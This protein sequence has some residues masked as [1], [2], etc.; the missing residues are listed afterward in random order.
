MSDQDRP[1]PPDD[2]PLI[3]GTAPPP[4][5]PPPPQEPDENFSGVLPPEPARR[6]VDPWEAQ[7]LRRDAYDLR[8]YSSDGP[9]AGYYGATRRSPARTA[10]IYLFTIMALVIGGVL[11]FLLFRVLNDDPVDPV[12]PT[13]PPI[14]SDARIESPM[15]R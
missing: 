4:P 5:P 1:R 10:A 3:G 13:P 8:A 14:E 7:R 2:E 12:E 9:R 11:I 15:T 6:T